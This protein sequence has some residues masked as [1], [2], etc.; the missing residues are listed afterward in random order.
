MVKWIHFGIFIEPA[1]RKHIISIIKKYFNI[2]SSAQSRMAGPDEAESSSEGYCGSG[3]N[4]AVAKGYACRSVD[5]FAM[6]E[7]PNF[8]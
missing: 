4:G 5:T 7:A 6:K 8:L 1:N 2:L 3:S